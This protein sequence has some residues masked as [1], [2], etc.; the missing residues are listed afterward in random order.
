MARRRNGVVTRR[1]GPRIGTKGELD[2]QEPG[3]FWHFPDHFDFKIVKIGQ[4]VQKI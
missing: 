4:A 2:Y 3:S 1:E